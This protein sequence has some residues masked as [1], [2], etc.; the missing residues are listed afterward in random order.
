MRPTTTRLRF[1]LQQI[2]GVVE[3]CT[4]DMKEAKRL[5]T[6]KKA[7]GVMN[8]AMLEFH[9]EH[10]AYKFQIAVSIVFHKAVYTAVVTQ[11][12]A[13]LTSE[14]VAAHDNGCTLPLK[15]VNRQLLDCYWGL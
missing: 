1:T 14:L 15:D 3:K 11:P 2:R 8:P 7:L 4:V 6:L 10:Q 9:R 12:P 5:P 13:V